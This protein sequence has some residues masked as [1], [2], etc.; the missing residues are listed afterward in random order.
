MSSLKI[1]KIVIPGTD[2]GGESSLPPV[3]N[4]LHTPLRIESKL[5]EEEGLFLDYGN[6][7]NPFPYRIQDMY[8]RELREM[9]FDAVVLEND[10]LRAEFIPAL[11]GRLWSL[12]DKKKNRELLFKNP[13]FRPCN[14]AMR[15][16][17]F[18][19]GVE[20][21][22]GA[23]G[24]SA[25][26]CEQI[27][28][29]T[30]INDDGTPVLRMYA[31]ERI[32]SAVYQMDFF[33]PNDSSF[34]FARMRIVNPHLHVL[35]V[36]WWSN[37]AV[38]ETK[39]SRVIAPSHEVYIDFQNCMIKEPLPVYDDTDITYPANHKRSG[40]YFLKIRDHE[41]KYI[42]QLDKDGYGLVQTSTRK[43]LGR[44]MFVW[45]QG[46]GGKRWQEHLSAGGT[47]GNYVEIQAGLTP[48]QS[49]CIPMPP[50]TAWEWLEAYGAM[51]ANANNVHGDWNDSIKEAERKLSEMFPE[52]KMETIFT[53]SAKIVK[54]PADKIIAYGNG[55]GA[56]ENYRRKV[57]GEDLL[58]Q[59]LD[60]GSISDEQKPW[61]HLL[62][63]G[64]FKEN[65]SLETQKSWMNQPEWTKLLETAVTGVDAFNWT[66][67]LHL[68]AVYYATGEIEKAES[69]LE[70][71]MILNPS[72]WASYL[73]AKV[74]EAQEKP[75]EA[76]VLMM[77]ASLMKKDDIS[78]AK[79]AMEMLLN[80]RKYKQLLS[81]E[82]ELPG[83]VTS[84]GRIKLLKAFALFY[85]GDISAAE[86]VI[87]ENGGIVIADI[88]EGENSITDLWYAI[89]EKKAKNENRD[90]DRKSVIP[91]H[92][93]DY[94]MS[95]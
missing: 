50:G 40:S 5:G 78:L 73:L 2:L 49:E 30:L 29:A 17:W 20:W 56:L 35:P 68:G 84:N 58:S 81:L 36:Y 31:F 21:N 23:V 88:R 12:I 60:F 47:G 57:A 72:C 10:Y 85:S 4:T 19:G 42:C 86:N 65:D 37:I 71:S 28:S 39:D 94:R 59:H 11:G 14:L 45:G 54:K 38:P 89:E 66:T 74:K 15:N 83:E 63:T 69:I 52:D 27:F 51:N 75:E 80:A 77:K 48:T 70:T 61:I 62:E 16:A 25:Y 53:D 43:L 26:T 1:E 6:I 87:Y 76:A 24:H 67:H 55:W 9:T 22:F 33:L 46:P 3:A 79:A 82:R 41:R 64:Y 95:T 13:V 44:K 34:L 92:Q 8:T 32:R 90:F 7:R 91:P 18:S 93:F